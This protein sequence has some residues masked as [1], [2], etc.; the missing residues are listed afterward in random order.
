MGR[1]AQRLVVGAAVLSLFAGV[2]MVGA[3]PASAHTTIR[4]TAPIPGATVGGDLDRLEIRFHVPVVEPVIT[5]NS[6]THEIVPGTVEM[7]D[8]LTLRYSV[9]EFA[10]AG[11]YIVE[12]SV[13]TPDGHR[14]AAAYA[15]RYDPVAAPV[16]FDAW[17]SDASSGPWNPTLLALIVLATVCGGAA[18]VRRRMGHRRSESVAID[19]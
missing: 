15:F 14:D 11:E 16:D 9:D 12:W 5:V 4:A 10:E 13:V 6:P 1:I 17:D 19:H 18:L 7:V 2:G 3:P 8:S